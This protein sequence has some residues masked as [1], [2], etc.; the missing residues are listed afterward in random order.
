M[1]A[2]YGWGYSDDNSTTEKDI[3]HHR[4]G[5]IAHIPIVLYL[6]IC[7]CGKSNLAKYK[8]CRDVPCLL[9]DEGDEQ[10]R[11]AEI[12][13]GCRRDGESNSARL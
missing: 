7:A 8:G 1:C 12:V 4:P 11:V 9:Y 5:V 2:G 13:A 6:P 3:S 10:R